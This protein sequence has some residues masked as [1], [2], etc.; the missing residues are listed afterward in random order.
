MNNTF[1]SRLAN[2]KEYLKSIGYNL[3]NDKINEIEFIYKHLKKY[4]FNNDIALIITFKIQEDNMESFNT[5]NF[6]SL[7][8]YI[9]YLLDKTGGIN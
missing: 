6:Y 3:S 9:K 4:C 8:K 7:E 1:I 2:N 5:R